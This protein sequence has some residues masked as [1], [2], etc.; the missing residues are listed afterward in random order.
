MTASESHFM[1]RTVYSRSW[2][3][4]A[5]MTGGWSLNKNVY[6]FI[7]RLNNNFVL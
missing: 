2:G 7:S 5:D 1:S 4:T 3:F 6:L